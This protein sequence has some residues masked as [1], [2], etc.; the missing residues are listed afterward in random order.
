MRELR[1]I[2]SAI[3][4]SVFL[5]IVLLAPFHHH[6]QPSLEDVSCE[7]CS[8][9]QPHPGHLSSNTGT[10]DCLI[11][12]LLGQQYFP[13]EGIAFRMSQPACEPISE[14]APAGITSFVY[15]LSS[16]RAPPVSFCF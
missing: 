6:Q 12:Q 14:V 10:D 3:L 4:L 8:Q 11:C 5:P 15:S 13:S 7:A 16:P 9:H 2:S 1:R